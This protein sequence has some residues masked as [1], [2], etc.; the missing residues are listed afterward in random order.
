M[1]VA[2]PV[3]ALHVVDLLGV[4]HG[5]FCSSDVNCDCVDVKEVVVVVLCCSISGASYDL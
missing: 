3:V 5:E 4:A 1:D 2:S